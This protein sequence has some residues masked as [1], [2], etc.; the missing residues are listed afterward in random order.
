MKRRLTLLLL[1]LL[2]AASFASARAD[3]QEQPAAQSAE[4]EEDVRL[5]TSLV[6][7]YNEGKYDE[8]LPL[9][10]RVL[11]L[12]QKA[13]GPEHVLVALALRNMAT[14]HV[15]KKN[16][17]E[18]EK[19]YQRALDIFEKHTPAQA[20]AASDVALQLGILKFRARDYEKAEELLRRGV[21]L[22]ELAVGP[23]GRA[24]ALP[25]FVLGDAQLV[26]QGFDTAAPFYDRALTLL[27]AAPPQK[28]PAAVRQ[29]KEMLCRVGDPRGGEMSRRVQ[30]QLYR[31]ENPE[32]AAEHER[33]QREAKERAAAAPGVTLGDELGTEGVIGG[34]ALSK[35]QP[36][37]PAEAK[38]ARVSGRVTIHITVDEAGKVIKAEALC[39]P[40]ELRGASVQAA[41]KALFSPTLLAGVPV[42]VTGVITYNFV[43]Q[44]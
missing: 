38:R 15:E 40:E 8:A 26:R 42:K 29:L 12:R 30:R 14:I 31:V 20:S 32:K 4:S 11:E 16:S 37:Y 35:P 23:K 28:D 21:A 5:V 10:E 24:V 9:A 41:K 39:G 22:K 3:G 33:K 25:L 43:L 13:H 17:G 2:A 19:L 6:K 27:E 7:L 18:A 34:R 44:Y 1:T 36:A